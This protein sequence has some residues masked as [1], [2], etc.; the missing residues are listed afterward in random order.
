MA[1]PDQRRAVVVFAYKCALTTL[2]FCS[3]IWHEYAQFLIEIGDSTEALAVYSKAIEI[4]PL[5]LM[6]HFTYAELLESRKHSAEALPVYRALIERLEYPPDKTLS[7]IQF[8]KFIQRTEGPAAMR[9]EFICA[10]QTGQCTYQLVLAVA[11]IEN[12]VNV[13][14]DASLRI[15]MLGIDKYGRSS[16]FLEAVILGLI[17]MNA[18]DEVKSV[19]S[20]A[21]EVLDERKLVDLYHKLHEHLL[22]VR[23]KEELL[24]DVEQEMMR[25]DRTETLD[26]MALR[27]F[28]LPT[29]FVDAPIYLP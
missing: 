11:S 24:I 21:R 18:D 17:R 4:L 20:H 15:L 6:L 1:S 9:R 25:L 3:L 8:L 19:I 12:L 13:N 14:R 5:N 28:F 22:F 23:G 29:D 7:T 10:L 27:R 26:A 2:R 16:E